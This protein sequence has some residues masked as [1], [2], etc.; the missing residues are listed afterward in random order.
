MHLLVKEIRECDQIVQLRQKYSFRNVTSL[1]FRIRK[2]FNFYYDMIM[3][4]K[5]DTTTDL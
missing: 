3:I 5:Y 1:A 2:Y 4:P